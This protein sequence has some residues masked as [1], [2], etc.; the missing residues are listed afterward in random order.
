MILILKM[1]TY[2]NQTNN[3]MLIDYSSSRELIIILLEIHYERSV[4][5]Y[6]VTCF[7]LER[8]L[9]NKLSKTI[10][11][12]KFEAQFL[13]NL[14][15]LLP[16]G[17]FKVNSLVFSFTFDQNVPL[18]M[19]KYVRYEAESVVLRCMFLQLVLPF[20]KPLGSYLKN[21]Y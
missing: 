1:S 10:K 18:F 21:V 2:L 20:G 16:W 15:G 5:V 4:C 6:H 11:N 19:G 9:S 12:E 13:L 17:N 3:C 14:N 8:N 7:F